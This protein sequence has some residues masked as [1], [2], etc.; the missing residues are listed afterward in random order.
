MLCI[1]AGKQGTLKAWL[2]S[3]SSSQA[4]P[5]AQPAAAIDS[6]SESGLAELNPTVNYLKAPN[7]DRAG[8]SVLGKRPC[9]KVGNAKHKAAKQRGVAGQSSLKAFMRPQ[10]APKAECTLPSALISQDSGLTAEASLLSQELTEAQQMQIQIQAKS[11]SVN[12][13]PSQIVQRQGPPSMNMPGLA[14]S[15]QSGSPTVQPAC[16]GFLQPAGPHEAQGGLQRQSSDVSLTGGAVPVHSKRSCGS[17]RADVDELVDAAT[18]WDEVKGPLPQEP[19]QQPFLH[20]HTLLAQHLHATGPQ[21]S[22]EQSLP[23]KKCSEGMRL[24]TWPWRASLMLSSVCSRGR[25]ASSI[26]LA[27]CGG[28]CATAECICK[29]CMEADPAEDEAAPLQGPL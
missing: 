6:V 28:G 11:R 27:V 9:A 14:D 13:E 12:L 17:S 3:A 24:S 20:L 29:G 19:P 5:S 21:A 23:P 16:L 8:A 18:R 10:A 26:I 22:P 15:A 1:P 2:A 25:T 4:Q 7:E